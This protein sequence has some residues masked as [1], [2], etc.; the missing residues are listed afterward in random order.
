MWLCCRLWLRPQ[1]AKQSPSKQ[2]AN[3]SWQDGKDAHWALPV[4]VV[5]HQALTVALY[6]SDPVGADE[7]G[8]CLPRFCALICVSHP[9]PSAQLASPPLAAQ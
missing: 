6:D 8:R 1:A 9:W 7:I 4:H 2:G 5:A 3:V